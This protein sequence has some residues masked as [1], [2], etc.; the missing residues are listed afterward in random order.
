MTK[1][2]LGWPFAFSG[3]K[4]LFAENQR[5]KNRLLT[6]RQVV[7][8]LLG[9]ISFCLPLK[10]SAQSAKPRSSKLAWPSDVSALVSLTDK[11]ITT[12][13]KPRDGFESHQEAYHRTF[14][15]LPLPDIS[16]TLR[17]TMSDPENNKGTPVVRKLGGIQ[18]GGGVYY[19]EKKI[20]RIGFPSHIWGGQYFRSRRP[21]EFERILP[22]YSTYAVIQFAEEGIDLGSST[23]STRFGFKNIVESNRNVSWY[24]LLIDPGEVRRLTPSR[25]GSGASV[26]EPEIAV[27]AAEGRKLI[28]NLAWEIKGAVRLVPNAKCAANRQHYMS[29]RA[30]IDQPWEE[31][32]DDRYLP[33]NLRSMKLI[34]KKTGET[35]FSLP[36]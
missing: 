31:E 5:L 26:V 22:D 33:I 28:Q 14:S 19:P 8:L 13:A 36:E 27:D 2:I 23:A 11:L 30:T 17:I 34:N 25:G 12:C 21:Y 35:L 29:R 24:L 1:A 10:A 32:D 4:R 7:A 15:S 18:N 3:W 6:G 20:L 16:V 9:A